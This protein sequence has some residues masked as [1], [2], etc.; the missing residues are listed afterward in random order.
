MSRR[1]TVQAMR[2]PV[3]ILAFLVAA[4][5][6]AGCTSTPQS[7]EGTGDGTAAATPVGNWTAEESSGD[8][9]TTALVDLEGFAAGPDTVAVPAGATAVWFNGTVDTVAPDGVQV[10]LIPPG[11]Q[12]NDCYREA[13]VTGGRFSVDGGE[14]PT[15]GD[16][17]LVFFAQNAAQS[18]SYRIEVNAFVTG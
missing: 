9:T 4:A 13:N 6:L 1:P 10:R 5:L 16:W 8:F 7:A 11:C 2:R 12:R 18:G 15:S 3:L 14:E 17:G